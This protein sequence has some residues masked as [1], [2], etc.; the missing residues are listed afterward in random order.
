MAETQE[1]QGHTCTL[2]H[3]HT[4]IPLQ[5]PALAANPTTC[6]L[7]DPLSHCSVCCSRSSAS[8]IQIYL[9]KSPTCNP[10]S[11]GRSRR[12]QLLLCRASPG[13]LGRC[14]GFRVSA[15]PAGGSSPPPPPE[16]HPHPLQ[17]TPALLL[18]G[19]TAHVGHRDPARPSEPT[20]HILA[21]RT[22]Q[23]QLRHG[24]CLP[25]SCAAP[26]TSIQDLICA[27]S[28]FLTERTTGCQCIYGPSGPPGSNLV[29][30]SACLLR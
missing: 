12:E 27:L 25:T 28:S 3:T 19:T 15:Y 16:Q 17:G 9:E 7:L 26:L 2:T 5:C 14:P 18:P 10:L 23:P 21:V 30:N 22:A 20:S 8:L 4:Y 11:K 1:L 6:L 24:H 13:A 29:P